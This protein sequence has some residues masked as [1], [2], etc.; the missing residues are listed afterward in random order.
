VL[1]DVTAHEQIVW[2]I[3]VSPDRK[4]LATSSYDRSLHLVDL[5]NQSVVAKL[6]SVP[7][8][9]AGEGAEYLTITATGFFVSS[10]RGAR[11][12]Y[13]KTDDRPRPAKEF[14]SRYNRPQR[15]IQALERR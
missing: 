11:V 4:Q 6:Y 2:S 9:T 5:Q 15:V 12:T 1:G 10:E 8:S 14:A 7:A 13:L 3:A